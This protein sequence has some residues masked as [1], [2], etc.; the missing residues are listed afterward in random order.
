[1]PDNRG[2]PTARSTPALPA[3]ASGADWVLLM[4]LQYNIEL[5]LSKRNAVRK[6]AKAATNL[7]GW[8]RVAGGRSD[9]PRRS[10]AKAGAETSG[11]VT[12]GF[13]HAGD[14]PEVCN[15]IGPPVNNSYEKTI[16]KPENICGVDGNCATVIRGYRRA[17]PP[18]TFW[19]AFGLLRKRPEGEPGDFT[20]RRQHFPATFRCYRAYVDSRICCLTPLTARLMR[21]W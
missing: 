3:D 1:M 15:P 5:P 21:L 14:M 20:R 2:F 13:G 11:S 9:W 7:E 19:Q 12:M 6:G 10:E 16:C 8:Q 18:A 4:L 17:Q